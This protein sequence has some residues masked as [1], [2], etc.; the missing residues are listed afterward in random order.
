MI[1]NLK[2]ISNLFLLILLLLFNIYTNAQVF[3]SPD[4][5]I[6][7]NNEVIYIKQ[8]LDLNAISSI[9]YLRNNSQLLQGT[10]GTGTNKGLGKLSVFQEGSV[11]NFQFNYWCSPVGNSD[12]STSVNNPF[13]ISQLGIPTTK[14]ASTAANI[15]SLNNY[16]GT[17]LPFSIASYWVYKFI[18]KSSYTDW[19]KVGSAFTINPGEGFTMKGSSGIDITMVDGVQNNPDGKQQRY[20]FR[21]KP[22]D[23]T[24]DIEVLPNQFTLTGNPYPSAIDL[25]AF[26]IGETNCTGIAY[27]WEQDK[28]FNSH[29]ISDYKG[30]YGTYSAST[31]IYTPAIFYSYD[32]SG[33]QIPATAV[34]SGKNYERKYSPIGQGF[35]IEGEVLSTGN[36][37][38]KNSYRTFIKEG[39]ASLSQFEKRANTKSKVIVAATT[40]Q[41][42]FNTV[43]NN[44]PISQMVLA[45]DTMS[46]DGVN[47]AMDAASPNDGPC[48]NYFVINDNEYVIN[49]VPFDIEKRIPIG[50][51]NS[52]VA[53]Y[54]I[55]INEILNLSE[56]HNVYLYD[57]VAKIYYDIKNS[58]FEITLPAGTNN[59][60]FEITFKNENLNLNDFINQ[61]FLVQQNNDTKTLTISNP[62]HKELEFYRLYDVTGKMI[63]E[64][65]KLGNSSTYIFT[66]SNLID[67]IYIVKLTSNDTIQSGIKIIVKN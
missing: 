14:T 58:F 41:I 45:F 17:S 51:K 22:N 49:V 52:V 1:Q 5:E 11:N 53:N 64:K 12:L 32:G 20:D 46:T 16:D 8:G 31:N 43:L 50:F 9:F 23:G 30:G 4:T 2:K 28:T 26:L 18:V 7:V 48:N 21:G 6:L 13:G 60:Q 10:T 39:L 33:N 37:Q 24:I 27:F 36:V 57:K 19:L 54:K 44:G 42:R 62:F 55:T 61:N 65:S 67:G 59:A 47:R 66:T 3:V 25:Q 29:Y 38:M 63:I 40:P 15:L 35:M 56:I 34:S